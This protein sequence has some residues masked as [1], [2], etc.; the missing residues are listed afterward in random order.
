[1]MG[2]AQL[3]IVSTFLVLISAVAAVAVINSAV[4]PAPTPEISATEDAAREAAGQTSDDSNTPPTIETLSRTQIEQM[5]DT[6]D[7]QPDLTWYDPRG[8]DVIAQTS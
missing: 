3:L 5:L 6:T 4:R 1:M 8:L 2:K 7:V